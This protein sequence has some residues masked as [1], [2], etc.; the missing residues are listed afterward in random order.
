[1]ALPTLPAITGDKDRSL[2]EVLTR[3][4]SSPMPLGPEADAFITAVR[5]LP[6][7]TASFAP[8]PDG[9]DDRLRAALASRGIDQLYTHQAEAFAH[10]LA[11]RHVVTVTPTAS[12]KTLCYNGPV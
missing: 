12:G 6:A 11:G 3:L 10:V 1:M 7:L 8:F 2:Q 9:T 5:R 4:A